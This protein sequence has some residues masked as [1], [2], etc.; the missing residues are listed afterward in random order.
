MPL[1]L[2]YMRCAGTQRAEKKHDLPR[3][4]TQQHRNGYASGPILEKRESLCPQ[5]TLARASK[6]LQLSLPGP[7]EGGQKE[8]GGPRAEC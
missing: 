7:R 3:V 5:E 4:S 1:G 2:Y 8:G 6:T